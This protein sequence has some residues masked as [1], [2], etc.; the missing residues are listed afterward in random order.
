MTGCVLLDPVES[1]INI[2]NRTY[3]VFYDIVNIKNIDPSNIKIDKKSSK[4]IFIYCVGYVTPNSVKPLYLT[5]NNA[6]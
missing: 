3:C 4:N 6:N 5:I 1:V 2:I